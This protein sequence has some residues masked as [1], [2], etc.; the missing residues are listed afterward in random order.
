MKNM[1]I[2]SYSPLHRDPRILRQI[3]TFR[4]EFSIETIG[5]TD[6][7]Q[8]V[9]FYSI[10]TVLY[11]TVFDK[12]RFALILL[13][14]N[15]FCKKKYLDKD[16]NI[17][18][19]RKDNIANPDIIIANDWNGLYAACRLKEIK[20]WKSKIYFDSHE[21]FPEYRE[22]L[23]WKFF[24]RPQILY[25]LKKYKNSFD[26]MSTVC[27]T[28]ARMY[29]NYFG[30]EENTIREVTNSPDYEENLVPQPVN[31]KIRIIHHGGAMKAR[32]LEKM[33]DMME[34]LPAE[35]YELSFML[36]QS[37]KGY[38]KELVTRASKYKNVHFLE[39]VPF[40][41]IPE[42]TNQ[43]DIGCYILDNKIINNRYALPNKFFEFVQA[44][45]AIAIGDSPEMRNYLEKYNL[46]V[47]AKSNSPKALAE[48]IL[49]LS[50]DDI[51]RFKQ[52]AHKYAEELSAESNKKLLREIVEELS[53]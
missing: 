28:L 21:Y 14:S 5:Y 32:Q 7:N 48:E 43:F 40:E 29:E 41:K 50:K 25:T 9:P 49:K 20:E 35:K 37:D 19:L 2:I 3:E 46:G 47:S 24:F 33:I 31:E 53:K 8:N 18:D 12:M 26:I 4:E 38:Y 27:P 52:N 45:L 42:F 36:V 23:V 30:F 10:S 13:F 39:P 16:L 51:F 22:S 11:K 15:I 1:L 6:S 17:V 44:R 34:Y